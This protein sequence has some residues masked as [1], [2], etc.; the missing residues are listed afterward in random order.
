MCWGVP[1]TLVEEVTWVMLGRCQMPTRVVRSRGLEGR[2]VS[3]RRGLERRMM[4]LTGVWAVWVKSKREAVGM[5]MPG[6]KSSG[7]LLLVGEIEVAPE[8]MRV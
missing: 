7:E 1:W 2:R 4:E 5:G 8:K 6:A 3:A